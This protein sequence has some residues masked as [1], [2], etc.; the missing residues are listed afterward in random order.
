MKKLAVLFILFL[1]VGVAMSY[2]QDENKKGEPWD[3][4]EKY[5]KMDNPVDMDDKQLMRVGRS[6][7][8]RFCKSCHGRNGE[9]DGPKARRLDTFPGDFTTCAFKEQDDGELYYK[10]IIGR[11]EMPNYEK[12]IPNKEDRWA[13]IT[14]IKKMNKCDK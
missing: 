13:V 6:L 11:D 12:K 2:G 7:Y 4:P 8:S 10:S 1:A 14:Y 3:I 9:G 5:N